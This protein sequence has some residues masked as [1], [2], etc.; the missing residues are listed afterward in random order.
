[1]KKRK[2]EC[3]L[4]TFSRIIFSVYKDNIVYKN[5]SVNSFT[6]LI[7]EILKI[8]DEL[9]DGYIITDLPDKNGKYPKTKFDKILQAQ[10]KL[11]GV[12]GFDLK[13]GDIVYPITEINDRQYYV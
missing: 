11:L 5:A 1:M 2:H 7:K 13:E 6:P 8:N 3:T 10:K 4:E 9:E 12:E